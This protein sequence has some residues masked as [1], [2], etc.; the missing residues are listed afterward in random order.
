M[1]DSIELSKVLAQ[2][3]PAALIAVVLLAAFA[4]AA[5]AIYAI[6]TATKEKR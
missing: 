6:L 3:S 1:H 4:L 2:M 5:Y